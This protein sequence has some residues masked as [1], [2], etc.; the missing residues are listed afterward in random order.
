[1]KWMN[2]LGKLVR[3]EKAAL[4]EQ[5]QSLLPAAQI[6]AKSSFNTIRKDQQFSRQMTMFDMPSWEFFV[7]LALVNAALLGL[8]LDN[9]IDDVGPMVNME[10]CKWNPDALRFLSD[11]AK[12]LVPAFTGIPVKRE[13]SAFLDRFRD[14]TG[15]WVLWN[16]YGRVPTLEESQLG[17]CIGFFAAPFLDWWK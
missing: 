3:P 13:S 17:R 5:L 14:D 2:L 10:V 16:L 4:H 11:C 15:M 6:A 9:R 8:A 1:M 12:F 7:T